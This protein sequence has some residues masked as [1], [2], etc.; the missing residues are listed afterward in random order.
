MTIQP[1]ANKTNNI[2]L[3]QKS[4]PKEK[5]ASS[6]TQAAKKSQDSVDMSAVAKEIT[7][8]FES[9]NQETGINEN[10]VKAVREALQNETYEIN[11]EK[12][13][14]KMIQMEQEQFHSPPPS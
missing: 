8:A 5:V 3:S 1:L 6:D 2:V 14:S 7:R 12:I 4:T 13:A 11:A 9:P 10:R